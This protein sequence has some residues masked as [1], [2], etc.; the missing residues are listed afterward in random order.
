METRGKT[1]SY[2]KKAVNAYYNRNKENDEFMTKKREM[3]N[4]SYNKL[5][6]ENPE[7]YKQRREQYNLARKQKRDALKQQPEEDKHEQIE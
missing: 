3:N 2:I 4:K 5:K 1:P 7:L 6:I